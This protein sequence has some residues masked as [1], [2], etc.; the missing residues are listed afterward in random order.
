MNKF[1]KSIKPIF[2]I[3]LVV[4]CLISI[5][6][7]I[8]LKRYSRWI[9]YLGIVRGA[10]QRVFKLETNSLPNDE[11]IKYIDDILLNLLNG[12][13]KYNFPHINDKEYNDNLLEL[14]N[15]WSKI[16]K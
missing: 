16:K 1:G 10:S 15:K 8:Q 4:A 2:F 11:L 5:N 14:N 12:N 7:I 13:G 9:N 3:L 6:S